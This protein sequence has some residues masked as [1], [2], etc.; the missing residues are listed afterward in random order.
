MKVLVIDDEEIMR[1]TVH[2]ALVD[3]RFDAHS[4]KC[5]EDALVALQKDTYHAAV[6]DLKMPGMDGLEFLELTRRD[7]PDLAVIMITAHGTVET[8]VGAMKMGA[9][10][11]LTKPFDTDEL[12]M[13]LER[14]QESRQ[15]REEN[16]QLKKALKQRYG[17]HQLVGKS[18]G[19]QNVYEIVDVVCASDCTVL[20]TGETGT[21][22][23]MVANA[24]HYNSERKNGPM[25]AVSCATLSPEILE[26]ELF[27]HVRGAFTGA[28]AD[29]KGRFEIADGG[30]LFLDEVDDIPLDL[31]V[32]LLRV[33]EE[34][35]Y[36]RVGSTETMNTDVRVVAASKVDLQQRA[37]EG[38]FRDD[39]FY[40]LNQ[41][42]LPLP[43][44][45][46]RRDDISL[47]IEHFLKNRNPQPQLSP[48]ALD[49]LLGYSWPGNVRELKNVIERLALFH[50]Q[51]IETDDLPQEILARPAWQGKGWEDGRA[52]EDMI[53]DTEKYL[54]RQALERA[55]NNQREAARLL[56]MPA[57]SFHSRLERH[58]LL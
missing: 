40:R 37:A 13:I 33:L 41:V 36:E 22:K 43:P 4:C 35:T 17:F 31:Q 52:F 58:G 2:N 53:A 30:T 5:A 34:G 19:M 12:V 6:V 24:I 10:D 28:S 7:Y 42:P 57:S 21:G 32:K 18:P 44:L 45:R 54:L 39:L 3:A 25:I 1:V 50:P 20:I 46:E 47:L 26:S 23:G 15:V 27:G 49:V 56:S 9:Y 51:H 38:L 48:T 16:R 55:N 11:Y 8:A 14:Y 29:R